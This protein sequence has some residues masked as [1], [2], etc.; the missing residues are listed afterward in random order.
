[1]Q[2]HSRSCAVATPR[3]PQSV[4]ALLPE[5]ILDSIFAQFGFNYSLDARWEDR[6]ERNINLNNVSVVAEGWTRPARRLLFRSVKIWSW[7]H[8]QEVVEEGVGKQ[9]RV[10]EI[11]GAGWKVVTSQEPADAVSKLLKQLPNLRRLRLIDPPFTSFSPIESHKMQSTILLPHLHD[12]QISTDRSA[13]SIIFD[14]LATSNHGLS[15]LAVHSGRS[16][17]VASQKGPQQLDFR[18]NLRFLTAGKVLY[19]AL[20][21]P[22]RVV[23]GGLVGL[24]ELKLWRTAARSSEREVELHRVIGPTLKTLSFGSDELARLAD[25]LP[26]ISRVPR[27]E[28]TGW[29]D[30]PAPLLNCLPPSITFLQ[31]PSDHHLQPSFI[32]WAAIPSLVP[33]GLKQISIA[34]ISSVDSFRRLPPIQTLSMSRQHHTLNMLRQISPGNLPF[35]TIAFYIPHSYLDQIPLL[36]AECARLGVVFR[37]RMESSDP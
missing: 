33:A 29:D 10:L 34:Y 23:L 22:D 37:R 32:R 21:D 35:K 4:A 13:H 31:F 16:R 24:D 15:R 19:R 12:L 1:M 6:D 20:M 17:P 9:V 5:E 7:S 8:M 2:T 14:L 3:P 28:I 26:L 30:D 18:G 36:R 25:F 27:L 11:R